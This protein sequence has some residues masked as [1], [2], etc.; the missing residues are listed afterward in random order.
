MCR[1]AMSGPYKEHFACFSCRK[2]FKQPPIE[3]W[4]AVRDLG[5][6][7]KEL[8]RLWLHKLG[9][10]RREEELGHRLADLEAEYRDAVHNCP[11]CGEPMADMGLDFKPPRQ[12]DVRAW[13]ALEGLLRVGHVFR[14]CGCDGPGFI[15]RTTGQYREYLEDRMR[16]YA[17]HLRTTQQSIDLCAE[18]KHESAEYWAERVAA[19]ESEL[20]A[21]V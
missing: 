14:T 15:P 5:Y 1:Y 17:E 8:H 18:R 3:D 12:E 19:V 4:L 6:V 13:R 7:Y 21:L 9:L 11:E 20:A 2:A 16:L 10:E